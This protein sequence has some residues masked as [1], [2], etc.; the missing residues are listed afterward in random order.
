[1]PP[2]F[3]THNPTAHLQQDACCS[4]IPNLT[5]EAPSS[6]DDLINLYDLSL[7]PTTQK[8]SL[9]SKATP[10]SKQVV[11]SLENT[12]DIINDLSQSLIR[13]P[14][15]HCPP[16][17]QMV[18]NNQRS[19]QINRMKEEGNIAFKGNNFERAVEI[20]S[21]AAEAAATRPLFEPSI[22][23][24]EELSVVLCNRAAAYQSMKKWVEALCD[25]EAVIKLKRNW[26]KG[27]F[28]KAKALEGMGK[29]DE[30]KDA[31]LLGLE[32]EPDNAVCTFLELIL[33]L[34][35]SF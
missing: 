3:S 28:R 21:L 5:V 25:A 26:S 13:S 22:W 11:S 14:F 32:F 8:V 30:A 33:N 20:Y 24:K 7:D 34:S 15:P 4:H 23:I 31:A 27:H 6:L 19:Q 9:A 10:N 12:L 16:Q 2:G 17:P 1:M 35:I 29:L 18:Q